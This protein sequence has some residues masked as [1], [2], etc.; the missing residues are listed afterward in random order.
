M[1]RNYIEGL[2]IVI[3]T[4]NRKEQLSRLLD[5][6]FSQDLSNLNEIIIVDNNSDYEI[7]DI[8]KNIQKEN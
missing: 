4:Y 8:T 1:K 3:P 6:V 2:S 5:S 7:H